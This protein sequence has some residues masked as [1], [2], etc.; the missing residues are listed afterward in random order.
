L[1][2]GGCLLEGSPVILRLNKDKKPNRRMIQQSGIFA[3]SFV[4]F[5][6]VF[7]VLRLSFV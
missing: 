3:E 6:D 4:G 2:G 5:G 7:A 1:K